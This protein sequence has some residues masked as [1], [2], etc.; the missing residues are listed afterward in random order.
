ME[1]V[2]VE[3]ITRP[4]EVWSSVGDGGAGMEDKGSLRLGSQC[5]LLALGVGVG[6]AAGHADDCGG[7]VGLDLDRDTIQPVLST[8]D[9]DLGQISVLAQ[10]GQQGLGLGVTSTDVV[11]K[12][13]GTILGHHQTGEQDTDE[14]E[15]WTCS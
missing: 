7:E 5:D 13:L 11:L 1:A 8:G 3:A 12:D 14:G 2:A 4:P 15:A 6:V 9:H 10:Q